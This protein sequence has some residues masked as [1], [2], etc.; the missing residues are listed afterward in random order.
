MRKILIVEGL[1]RWN[2]LVERTLTDAGYRVRTVRAVVSVRRLVRE[3][4]PDLVLIG[5]GRQPQY[6]WHL[7]RQLKSD[8]ANLPVLTYHVV[9][10]KA[11][12]DLKRAVTAALG[13]VT[14][15]DSARPH[16]S[17]HWPAPMQKAEWPKGGLNSWGVRTLIPSAF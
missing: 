2:T 9:S 10:S 7:L 3:D 15:M 14:Y 11:V 5:L 6:G 8:D 16:A 13:E 1:C 12:E 17:R 4:R